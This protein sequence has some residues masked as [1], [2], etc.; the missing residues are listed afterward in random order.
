MKSFHSHWG[1]VALSAEH[2]FYRGQQVRGNLPLVDQSLDSR[3]HSRPGDGRLIARAGKPPYLWA[4][5]FA[6]QAR[7]ELVRS[8][9]GSIRNVLLMGVLLDALCQWLILGVSYAGAALVVGPVLIG[10]PY[11]VA[12]ALAN[13]VTKLRARHVRG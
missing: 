11:A 8:S 5:L 12:R 1:E 6:G 9:V 10:V 13:R 2:I 3:F 4:L 7:G